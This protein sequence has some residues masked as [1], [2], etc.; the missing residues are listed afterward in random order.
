[1]KKHFLYITVILALAGVLVVFIT[2]PKL[3]NVVRGVRLYSLVFSHVDQID[4]FNVTASGR[5]SCF[6][7]V[8][9]GIDGLD[10]A[11][12]STEDP[13]DGIYR[14]LQSYYGIE[15]PLDLKRINAP[16]YVYEQGGHHILISKDRTTAF[17]ETTTRQVL[18]HGVSNQ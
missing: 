18:T 16:C 2:R 10:A 1:M 7:L 13:K 3:D 5:P 11:H 6:L 12:L 8:S 4:V 9:G 17:M 15:T 14:L